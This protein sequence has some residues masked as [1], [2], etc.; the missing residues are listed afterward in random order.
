MG[1]ISSIKP[2]D[3][4]ELHFTDEAASVSSSN[5]QGPLSWLVL[6]LEFLIL[7]GAAAPSHTHL[8]FAL[9][10]VKAGE[11]GLPD[12]VKIFVVFLFFE[13][14]QEVDLESRR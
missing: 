2:K 5:T 7:N 12:V 11:D 9:L 3:T 14:R 1:H 10:P 13:L 4:S 8:R 6:V